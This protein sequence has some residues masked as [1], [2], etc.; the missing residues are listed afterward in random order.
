MAIVLIAAQFLKRGLLGD[1]SAEEREC[2]TKNSPRTNIVKD[3]PLSQAVYTLQFWLIFI[4]FFCF[5]CC[6]Y[7]IQVHIAP[8]ITDTGI[9]TARAA[10]MLAVVG[11]T[12]IV[13]RIGLGSL[14]DRIGKKKAFII[15]FILIIAALSWL[16]TAHEIWQFYLFAVVFGAAFGNGIANQAPLVATFFGMKSHGILLGFLCMGYTFGAAGGPIILGHMYDI[17]GN[18]QSAFITIIVI[19]LAG[20]FATFLL[21]RFK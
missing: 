6:V 1:S 21:R 3:Y 14:G 17:A 18:Y 5:G 11:A 8:H 20:L 7:A 15:G 2:I 16:L 19:A 4:L 12:G 13:G 10:G 9:S